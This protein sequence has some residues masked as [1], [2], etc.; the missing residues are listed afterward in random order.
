LKSESNAYNVIYLPKEKKDL[1]ERLE[2]GG[3]QVVSGPIEANI[4]PQN[5]LETCDAQNC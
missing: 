2:K 4:L 1:A 3:F 5:N